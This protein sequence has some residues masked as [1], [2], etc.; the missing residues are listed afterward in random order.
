MS[1]PLWEAGKIYLPG[2]LVQPITAAA[3]T[4]AST[5]T[6]A[7]FESGAT[8]WT[9][10]AR[11]TV[12]TNWAYAG[13]QS[14]EFNGGTSDTGE[15]ISNDR[16]A[17]D[18]GES[19]SVT[20]M[21]NQG[22]SSSNDA[23]AAVRVH[24]YDAAGAHLSYNEGNIIK[25]GSSGAAF[26]SSVTASAPANT[27]SFSVGANGFHNGSGQPVWVDSFVLTYTPKQ[28]VTGLIY[29]A[30]QP[31]PGTSAATEPVWPS[32]LGVQVIDNTVT[33]EAVSISRVV[34]ETFPL[35]TSGATEP[36]WPT[37]PGA[38]IVD[39]TMAWECVSR[40]VED[41]NCPNTKVVCILAS[42]V[43]AA[44]GDI[45][46]FSATANPLD[47]TTERDAGYLPTGLQQAN[48]N[49]TAVLAPYRGNLAGLNASSFQ[50]WQVDP[51]PALMAMLDQMEGIGST[52][53]KAAQPVG[54][55]LLF[56][57]KLGVRSVSIAAGA[58]NLA[59]GDVGM[60]V[61]PLVQS[62]MLSSAT[63]LSFG[64]GTTALATYYPGAGQYWLVLTRHQ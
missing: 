28:A 41:T 22:A 55:D 60:P 45:V 18:A 29:K 27:A 30:V 51:D 10:G 61:D 13:T 39:G 62:A 37:D 53:P 16:I 58:D 32:T 44:D 38:S 15:F 5:L 34:W 63:A 59:A 50:V 64:L 42:K 2:D 26:A 56:L 1:L 23:G 35:L 36:V 17:I 14:A 20:C 7:G 6:N 4:T 11:W 21:V 31:D 48:A 19:V 8:G 46:R 57:T 25:S 52:W 33:W 43:Y 9:L 40:R 47:W 12:T 54:N 3:A 24:W 49:D